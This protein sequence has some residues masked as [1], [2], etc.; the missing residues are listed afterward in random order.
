MKKIVV[1]K[2][3]CIGC[4]ACMAIDPEH[5]DFDEEGLSKVI[6]ND[7]L[8]SPTLKEGIDACPTTAI[9]I[10]EHSDN[11]TCDPCECPPGECNC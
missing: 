9:T 6:K 2:S 4:G 11:C 10:E 8:E 7:N 1:S 3:A 5:F